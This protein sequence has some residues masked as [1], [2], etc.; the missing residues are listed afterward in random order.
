MQFVV[1]TKCLL[2]VVFNAEQKTDPENK[3]QC[4]MQNRRL[5]LKT[6]Y[7]HQGS[8]TGGSVITH[9]K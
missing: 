2:I 1:F 8:L 4:L 7:R 3:V 5:I 6:K 9:Y